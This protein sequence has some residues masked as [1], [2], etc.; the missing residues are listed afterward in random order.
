MIRAI[1]KNILPYGISNYFIEK[2][3]LLKAQKEKLFSEEPPIYNDKAQKLKSVF[4]KDCRS[5][6]W[7]YSFVNGRYPAYLFFDRYN[8]RLQNHFY[9]HEKI[10]HITGKPTR[11]F[12][13]IL[14]SREIDPKTYSLYTKHPGLINEFDLLFTHSAELLEKY[15]NA[16]FIPGG[17]IYYGTSIH[18]GIMH[19][20]QYKFKTNNISLVS[21]NK[22]MCKLHKFRLDLARH[23]KNSSCVNTYGNFDG[24]QYIKISDSLTNYRYSI[25][26]ENDITPYRFTEKILNCFASMTIPIYIGAAKIGDFFNLD[27]IIQIPKPD[28]DEVNKA[29]KMCC[30]GDYNSRLPAI[31]DNYNRVQNYLCI[32]DYIWDNY[33]EHFI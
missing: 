14:E 21:S 30:E 4:L 29:I 22:V 9:S 10:L 5:M 19:N 27:G 20:D 25:V 23:Y 32:E 15:D 18:G 2:K 26:I 28:I 17:G 16:A 12:A 6:D 11:K 8:Y 7:P 3:A 1:I 31:I 33:R 13:C 24:G